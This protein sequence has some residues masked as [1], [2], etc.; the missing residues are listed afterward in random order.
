MSCTQQA[1]LNMLNV[2][3]KS[4]KIKNS[5]LKI[6]SIFYQSSLV[7]T[8]DTNASGKFKVTVGDVLNDWNKKFVINNVP[9]PTES[10][11]NILMYIL[12]TRKVSN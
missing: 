3:L 12:K 10:I 5:A 11:E 9:E 8:Y 4:T 2:L 7:R 6:S 1:A